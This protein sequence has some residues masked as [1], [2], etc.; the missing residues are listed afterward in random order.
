[1]SGALNSHDVHDLDLP[2]DGIWT[3]A[4]AAAL[5]FN[6]EQI[7]SHAPGRQVRF[8]GINYT[9]DIRGDLIFDGFE[10]KIGAPQS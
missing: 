2:S 8:G 10:P 6:L 7:A 5:A 1:M 9:T 4:P 3:I